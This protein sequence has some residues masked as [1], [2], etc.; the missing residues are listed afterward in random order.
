MSL[1][2]LSLET[3]SIICTL[4]RFSFKTLRKTLPFN[5]IYFFYEQGEVI[6]NDRDRIV[7]IGTHKKDGRFR[8]RIRQHYGNDSSFKGNKNGS[9]FRKH[10]G[11]AILRKANPNDS[12]LNDWLTQNGPTFIEIEEVVS[13]TLREHF[14]FSC[15]RVDYEEERLSLEKGLI[16]LFAQYPL[17]KPSNNWLGYYAANDDIR[18]SGLWNTQHIKAEPLTFEQIKRIEQLIK[19]S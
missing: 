11:G 1:Y 8:D 10:L 13:K 18:K 12:R 5:G 17:G 2:N 3:Y 9:V 7:R 15:F 19:R 16:A 4:P 6:N 14:T